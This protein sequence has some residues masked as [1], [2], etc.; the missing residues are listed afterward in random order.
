M[1]ESKRAEAEFEGVG[2]RGLEM[3]R[4]EAIRSR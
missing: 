3:G 4:I 2:E 1:A